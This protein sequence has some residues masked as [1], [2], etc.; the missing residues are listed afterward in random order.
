MTQILPFLGHQKI[1]D[2][3][4]YKPRYDK[5]NLQNGAYVIPS[6]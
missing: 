4:D 6:S 3:F 5:V 2:K 1:Y